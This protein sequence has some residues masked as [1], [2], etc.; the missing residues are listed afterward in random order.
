MEPAAGRGGVSEKGNSMNAKCRRVRT[1]FA[2]ETSFEVRPAPPA[3]FRTRQEAELERLKARLLAAR[4]GTGRDAQ[5]AAQLR[6]AA[7]EAAAL[8]WAT[9]YPLL[10]FPGLFEELA[11]AAM[12]RA[13]RQEQIRQRSREL[14]AA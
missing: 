3:P 4:L 13:E 9:R 8:A 5:F 12:L 10:L 2:P 14:L 7:A 1:R 11:E 6:R